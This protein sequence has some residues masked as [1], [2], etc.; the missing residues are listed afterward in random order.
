M[1]GA[2]HHAVCMP[3]T[4]QEL[5]YRR[6]AL[7]ALCKLGYNILPFSNY[8]DLMKYILMTLCFKEMPLIGAGMKDELGTAS[9]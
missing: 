4:P 5:H 6:T 2:G 9:G 7:V 8:S 3:L 1:R